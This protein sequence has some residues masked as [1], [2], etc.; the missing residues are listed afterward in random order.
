MEILGDTA[1]YWNTSRRIMAG[2]ESAA[3][4]GRQWC[5]VV[6]WGAVARLARLVEG[7][8]HGVWLVPKL[9]A[10]AVCGV[11]CGIGIAYIKWTERRPGQPDPCC[12]MMAGC[13]MLLAASTAHSAERLLCT[14]LDLVLLERQVWPQRFLREPGKHLHCTPASAP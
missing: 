14:P 5:K 7:V 6:G 9:A 13:G 12:G 11:P 3:V 8:A 4:V 2:P 1:G 10:V